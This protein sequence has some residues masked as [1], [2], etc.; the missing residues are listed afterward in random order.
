MA[1]D[2]GTGLTGSS[3]HLSLRQL[4]AELAWPLNEDNV[5]R[6]DLNSQGYILVHFV[7]PF[8]RG[9]DQASFTDTESEIELVT[10]NDKGEETPLSGIGINGAAEY[11]DGLTWRY[12]FSGR[13]EP[14]R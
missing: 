14:G 7:D 6:N 13:F 12:R 5:G 11:V 4:T 8:G 9:L 10:V 1:D 3:E 2:S